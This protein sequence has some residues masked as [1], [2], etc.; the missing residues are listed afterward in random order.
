MRGETSGAPRRASGEAAFA[1]FDELETVLHGGQ[2]TAAEKWVFLYLWRRLGAREGY[3]DRLRST[4]LADHLGVHRTSGQ[5]PLMNLAALGY[6]EII[7]RV[8]MPRRGKEFEYKL[9]VPDPRSRGQPK[10]AKLDGQRELLGEDLEGDQADAEA[11]ASEGIR[12]EGVASGRGQGEG[13]SPE[14]LSGDPSLRLSVEL[15]GGRNREISP[16]IPFAPQDSRSFRSLQINT[17]EIKDQEIKKAEARFTNGE[18]A[19]LGGR[20][21]ENAP[22]IAEVGGPEVRGRQSD[23]FVSE[24]RRRREE[25]QR[26]EER[27]TPRAIDASLA[28]RHSPPTSLHSDQATVEAIAAEILTLVNRWANPHDERTRYPPGPAHDVAEAVLA[29]ELTL[30]DVRKVL[31]AIAAARPKS[32]GAYADTCFGRLMA[33]TSFDYRRFGKRSPK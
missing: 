11:T 26:R 28:T 33:R 12:C 16:L 10:R 15:S 21:R 7:D 5:K 29:G 31:T 3:I 6:V 17:Q 27:Q 23:P 1:W 30:A 32:A 9:Y 13:G 24:L 8:Q 14:S 4:D 2:L 18:A 20:N 22:L 25:E 19:G